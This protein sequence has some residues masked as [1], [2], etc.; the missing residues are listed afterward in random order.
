MSIRIRKTI[1]ALAAA[2]AFTVS[3]FAPAF[4]TSTNL[5]SSTCQGTGGSSM[6]QTNGL[7]Y[8]SGGPSGCTNYQ[9]YVYPGWNGSYGYID[10]TPTWATYD[11]AFSGP[12]GTTVVTSSHN[13]CT[14]SF[15][16]CNG[17]VSTSS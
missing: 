16:S 9:R 8:T 2:A 14:N 4:A 15:S 10:G 7:S 1:I 12:N 5:Y 17:Y 3:S 11:I 13:L 6:A